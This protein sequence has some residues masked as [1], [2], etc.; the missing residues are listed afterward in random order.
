MIWKLPSFSLQYLPKT[1]NSP[2]LSS[3]LELLLQLQHPGKPLVL[4]HVMEK[5]TPALAQPL[6]AAEPGQGMGLKLLNEVIIDWRADVKPIPPNS[7]ER[8][9][10]L[11]YSQCSLFSLTICWKDLHC[12]LLN[13]D[14][15]LLQADAFCFTSQWHKQKNNS[16]Q[17]SDSTPHPNVV[18]LWKA[19]MQEIPACP[20]L[21][22]NDTDTHWLFLVTDA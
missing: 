1:L 17:I 15:N 6:S 8:Q 5:T 3:A 14:V 16:P 20:G 13:T 9:S 19:L 22:L 21:I 18:K 11:S 12:V 7:V 10:A 4:K 2:K